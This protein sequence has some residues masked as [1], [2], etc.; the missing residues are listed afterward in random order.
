MIHTNTDKSKGH[1]PAKIAAGLAFAT[2]LLLG[3]FASSASA[4]DYQRYHRESHVRHEHR[5]GYASGGYY[6]RAP[7]VV[8]DSPYYYPPPVVYGP[9]FGVVTPGLSIDIR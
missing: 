4:Q 3:T 6:Y 9:R 7:P 8:Y 1:L 2:V 5:H